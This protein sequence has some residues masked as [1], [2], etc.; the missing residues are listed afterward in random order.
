MPPSLKSKKPLSWKV[1]FIDDEEGIRNV[2]KLTL[3]DAGYK[4][5]TAANGLQGLEMCAQESPQIVIT[6]F[7]MPEM[8]GIEVLQR[9]KEN[10]PDTEVIMVTGFG[11]MDLVS[12]ALQLSASDFINKPI[13][14]EALM[15]ALERAHPCQGQSPPIWEVH[16]QRLLTT[17]DTCRNTRT[18]PKSGGG[19]MTLLTASLF[20]ADRCSHPAIEV[21]RCRETS[22]G[23]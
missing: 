4:V 17:L 16:R 1:L 12:Q 11:D 6:D 23:I 7:R 21:L 13:Q 8:N 18:T 5:I 3:A 22:H 15:A 2:M 19:L 10:F 20:H 9:V 14:D